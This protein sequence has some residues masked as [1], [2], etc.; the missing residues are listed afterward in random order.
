MATWHR[1]SLRLDPGLDA[2]ITAMAERLGLSK[3]AVLRRLADQGE[4]MWRY[5]G[6]AFTGLDEHPHARI[7]GT[8]V[9]VCRVVEAHRAVAG[10]IGR[11]L[12]AFA[13]ELAERHI[14]LALAYSREFPEEVDARSS[15]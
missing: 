15:A 7:A 4:R 3:A 5:P 14:R 13:S 10:D 12:E 1:V 9:E 2:R 8:A 6:I 11:V